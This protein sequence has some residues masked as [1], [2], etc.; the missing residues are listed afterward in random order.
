MIEDTPEARER[1]A[2]VERSDLGRYVTTLIGNGSF[3]GAEAEL[4]S[5]TVWEVTRSHSVCWNRHAQSG[6]QNCGR[7]VNRDSR[8]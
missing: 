2:L 5:A 4:R 7:C 1:H 3:D 6:R 8:C